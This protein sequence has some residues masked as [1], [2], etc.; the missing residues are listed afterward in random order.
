MKL[1][2]HRWASAVVLLSSRR[3]LSL[4]VKGGSYQDFE[5]LIV[6]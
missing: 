5:S 6:G 2:L 4:A 3:I 1:R